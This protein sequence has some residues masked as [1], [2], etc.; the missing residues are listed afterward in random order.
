MIRRTVILLAVAVLAGCG[1]E[2]LPKKGGED[3]PANNGTG[4]TTGN[5]TGTGGNNATN[6]ATTTGPNNGTTT[7]P[8]NGTV[9]TNNQST[10]GTNGTSN[11]T[12]G[13]NNADC[14]L[15]V[16][17]GAVSGTDVWSTDLVAEP[18]STVSLRGT[19]SS[20]TSGEIQGYEWT[21]AARPVDSTT[22]L[23]PSASVAE[24]T[25]F[26]DLPGE[27]VVELEVTDA[28]GN[29]SC[30]PRGRVTIQAVPQQDIHVSVTWDTPADADQT[31]TI[32]ADLDLHFLHPNGQWNN[33]PW[34]IFWNNVTADWGN[35]GPADDPSLDLDDGDGAGPE[36]FSL[37]NPEPNAQYAVGVYYYSDNGFG[38]SYATVKIHLAGALAYEKAAEYMAGG[39]AFW[40]VAR[41][42]SSTGVMD[43]DT[44]Q[45]GF[46]ARP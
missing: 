3:D 2:R 4:G 22:R 17:E 44:H 42:Q 27:Y 38:P 29:P 13:T 40:Y 32:G 46:P 23:L 9:G 30:E 1:G 8:N 26:L 41:I 39:D 36:N 10:G 35:P 5:T 15:A 21:I 18:L 16:A 14:A 7:E 33:A 34:D 24:P 19:E 25:L 31:D 45:T 11:S 12:N 37:P 43:V 6:N 20:S 28:A